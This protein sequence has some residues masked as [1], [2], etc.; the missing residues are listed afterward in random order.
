[1]PKIKPLARLA[2]NLLEGRLADFIAERRV[3]GDGW[4]SWDSIAKDLW[5][6]TGQEVDVTG[7]TI[8]T[9]AD[10]LGVVE[11]DRAAS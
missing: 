1:M 2:D 10:D 5:T 8:Q 7:V 6:A 4:R 9:W 3:P 11:P